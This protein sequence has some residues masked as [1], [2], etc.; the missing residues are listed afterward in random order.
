MNEVNLSREVT[1]TVKY[2]EFTLI[3]CSN[4]KTVV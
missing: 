1:V 3:Y 2:L 4:D